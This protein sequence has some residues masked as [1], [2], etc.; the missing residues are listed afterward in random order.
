MAIPLSDWLQDFV[1]WLRD[2]L[3]VEG[4]PFS[5]IAYYSTDDETCKLWLLFDDRS[6]SPLPG[7]ISLWLCSHVDASADLL[8]ILVNIAQAKEQQ[9]RTVTNPRLP[10]NWHRHFELVAMTEIRQQTKTV[11]ATHL[12]MVGWIS[13]EAVAQRFVRSRLERYRHISCSSV[14]ACDL[15]GD[16]RAWAGENE[17]AVKIVRA[18]ALRCLH[19]RASASARSWEAL[20]RALDGGYSVTWLTWLSEFATVHE[21]TR[22]SAAHILQPPRSKATLKRPSDEAS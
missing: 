11:A 17:R 2:R 13:K 8:L 19:A 6:E 12:F 5:A 20:L 3:G 18:I 10:K 14:Y 22:I 4:Q 16:T 21:Q 1:Q 9:G 15:Q 7:L